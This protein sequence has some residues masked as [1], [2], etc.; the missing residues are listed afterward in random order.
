MLLI[1]KLP[2]VIIF[3]Y[4]C[5]LNFIIVDDLKQ[6]E[7]IDLNQYKIMIFTRSMNFKL[8]ELSSETVK[9]P[10]KHVRMK[11]TSA[12]GYFYEILKYA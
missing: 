2:N 10:F 1:E 3:L 7:N 5:G 11:H 6:I 4:L 9:L 12:D 8:F